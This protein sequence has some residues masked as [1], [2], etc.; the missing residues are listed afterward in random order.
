MT[1]ER[2][3]DIGSGIAC[4][5]AVAAFLG[6][7]PARHPPNGI[8]KRTRLG[9]VGRWR[10]VERINLG[11]RPTAGEMRRDTQDTMNLIVEIATPV[12]HD[13]VLVLI[14][15]DRY[16]GCRQLEEIYRGGGIKRKHAGPHHRG[17]SCVAS[18]E[19]KHDVY[20]A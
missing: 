6:F 2:Q 11:L 8:E 13:M 3:E 4:R 18:I 7:T 10:G 16:A 19:R 14:G 15:F 17:K 12:R 20:I 1:G 5:T 9:D